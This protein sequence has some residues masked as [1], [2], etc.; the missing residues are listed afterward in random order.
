MSAVIFQ[1]AKFVPIEDENSIMLS[2]H[3]GCVPSYEFHES[4]IICDGV[5]TTEHLIPLTKKP[6]VVKDLSTDALYDFE[7]SYVE[8]GLYRINKISA[9]ENERCDDIEPDLEDTHAIVRDLQN[10]IERILNENKGRT[11]KLQFLQKKLEKSNNDVK[12][13]N[14]VY[15]ELHEYI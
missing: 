8:S 14:D 10:N 4:V 5:D 15:E 7:L 11:K 6:K 3:I 1:K 12:T 9:S 13:V 2:V